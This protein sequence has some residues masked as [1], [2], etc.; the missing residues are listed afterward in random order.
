M[1]LSVRLS[2]DE[3]L[4]LERYC[5]EHGTTKSA[6]VLRLLREHVLTRSK[7]PMQLAEEAGIIGMVADE[8]PRDYAMK[9]SQYL[10]KKLRDKHARGHRSVRRRP[11]AA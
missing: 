10:K 9:H 2:P 8:Y 7:A 6:V 5:R 3:M 11:P 1:T 4:A